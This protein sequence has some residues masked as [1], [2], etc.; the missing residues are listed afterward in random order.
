VH[1]FKQIYVHLSTAA[2]CHLAPSCQVT[3]LHQLCA[4]S[5]QV[6][7]VHQK[8]EGSTASIQLPMSLLA[9]LA[10]DGGPKPHTALIPSLLQ[11]LP[12]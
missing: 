4:P 7:A 11:L 12:L 6:L 9:S 10:K 5:V 1:S 2:R 8:R 3:L